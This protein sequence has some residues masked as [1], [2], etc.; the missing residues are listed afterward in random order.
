MKYLAKRPSLRMAPFDLAWTKKL[1]R[2]VFG[3]VWLRAGVIRTNQTN[4]G[5]LPGAIEIDLQN[6]LDD[7]HAWSARDIPRLE[8]AARLH[9]RAVQ[10]HPFANGSGRW[11][12]TLATIWLRVH[13]ESI[14]E[15]AAA[16]VG[17]VGTVRDEY[18]AAPRA[19]DAAEH[20]S[21]L[22]MHR[23]FARAIE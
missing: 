9:H 15:W 2:E 22:A 11:S 5:S 19:A 17:A 7:L 16:T 10:M 12:R 6:L 3:Q 21:L 14:T 8:Q 13:R 20:A 23:H 1:H 4:I 18:F